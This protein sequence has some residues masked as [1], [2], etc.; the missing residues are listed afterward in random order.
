LL[1]ANVC[2]I[3]SQQIKTDGTKILIGW[4][5]ANQSSK[6]ASRIAIGNRNDSGGASL[7]EF[8]WWLGGGE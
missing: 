1:A 4:L 5:R 3:V 8:I 2:C 6:I 7:N